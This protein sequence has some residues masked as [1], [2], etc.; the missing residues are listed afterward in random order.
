MIKNNV[1]DGLASKMK[2][3]VNGRR[4][5]ISR[6]LVGITPV[7]RKRAPGSHLNGYRS[8]IWCSFPFAWRRPRLADS[9]NKIRVWSDDPGGRRKALPPM[10]DVRSKDRQPVSYAVYNTYVD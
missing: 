3:P 6:A 8:A 10:P 2:E 1:V 4:G 7:T 5:G 9:C